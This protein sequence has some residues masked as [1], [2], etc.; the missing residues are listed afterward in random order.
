MLLRVWGNRPSLR[1]LRHRAPGTPLNRFD[2]IS[3]LKAPPDHEI[4]SRWTRPALHGHELHLPQ[5]PEP[6]H[7]E[8]L[9]I[10]DTGDSEAAGPG[11]S[12]QDAVGRYMADALCAPV[13]SGA[14]QFVAHVGDLIYMTGERRLYER[15]FRRPYARLLT[16]DSTVDHLTFRVPF[17]PVPG[18]H[19]Y[20]DMGRWA[21]LL[22]LAPGLGTG[23]RTIARQLFAYNLSQGGSDQGRTYMERFIQPEPE[24]GTLPTPYLPGEA[25]R[26]PNRYYR[27]R[28]GSADFFCVDSNTLEAPPP[29]NTPTDRR[30]ATRQVSVLSRQAETIARELRRDRTALEN[31]VAGYRQKLVQSGGLEALTVATR[32][33]TQALLTLRQELEALQQQGLVCGP[34]L[35]AVTT[36]SS[37][38]VSVACD[39]E[40]PTGPEAA[41]RAIGALDSAAALCLECRR[42]LEEFASTMPDGEERAR[43]LLAEAAL[44]AALHDWTSLANGEPPD[45]LCRRLQELSEAALD[46]QRELARERNRSRSSPADHDAEQLQWLEAALDAAQRDRPDQWRILYLH[47]PLYSTIANHCE[48]RDVQG[49][50]ANLLERLRG[51]VHLILAGHSHAFEW[52]RAGELPHTGLFV[53]GGGG[54]ITLRRSVLD[55]RRL[56]R[57]RERYTAL[58]ES[59]VLECAVGGRGPA[60]PDGIGGP[61]YHFLRVKVTPD[62]L[63]VIPVGVR[64]IPSGFRQESPMPVYHASHL[65]PAQ[66]PWEPRTLEAVRIFRSE[67]PEP[68]WG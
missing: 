22:S 18:N 4:I 35:S 38:W 21:Q 48:H 42:D 23:L 59:G 50:R 28:Y 66:P 61:L 26:L 43:V 58:R 37:R 52:I 53:T 17:L 8:F 15:N 12:P 25:T 34:A 32:A 2:F 14:A 7:F 31:W 57:H 56:P 24:S 39:L 19:D 33:I 46:A 36:A 20:Y 40:A 45:E 3:L 29:T 10:G 16:P 67:A 1:R 11:I 55:P 9:A 27:F 5:P 6:D 51:K 63:L 44:E 13:G 30:S 54:Q 65:A 62:E 68:V 47:H 60:A 49:V 64:R 41:I